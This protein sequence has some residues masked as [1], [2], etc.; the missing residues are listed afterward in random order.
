MGHEINGMLEFLQEYDAS[1]LIALVQHLQV[2][3]LSVLIACGIGIPLGVLSWRSERT[4]GLIFTVANI[5]QT[6]PSIALFGLM[7]PVLAIFNSG[8][9]NV[10]AVVALVLYAQLPIIRNT[11]TALSSV[12]AATLDAA[13]GTGMT[14]REILFGIAMP[15]AA[16][17]IITGIRLATTLCIGVAAIAAYIGAGGL[18]LIIA[19]GLS[20]SW[21]T[22]I[23]AGG[24]G[25]ALLTLVLDILLRLIERLLAPKGGV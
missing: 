14:E 6:I 4:A 16:P 9:G 5:V 3:A 18:G 8:I 21:D 11:H 2:T 1:L 23:I 24:I 22:M 19:R 10:P 7:I 20:S 17:G 13:R 25:V 12:P 15:L